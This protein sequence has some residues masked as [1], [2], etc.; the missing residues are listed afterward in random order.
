M[1]SSMYAA[2]SG[3]NADQTMLSTVSENIANVNTVGYKA[4]SVVFAQALQQTLAGAS[5]PT[6]NLGGINP[7][8]E[9]AGSAVNVGAIAVN[10]G[11]GSLQTTGINTNL[12]IQG[13]GMF[14]LYGSQGTSYSRA[15]DF[16]LDANGNLVN[17]LGEFV[18]GWNAT[19]PGTMPTLNPT[20][21]QNVT[22]PQGETIAPVETSNIALN[23]NLDSQTP[24]GTAN[25]VTV[26]VTSYDSLGNGDTVVFTFT[27][28]GPT[29]TATSSW[30][31]SYTVT[32]GSGTTSTATSVGTVTFGANGQLTSPTAPPTYTITLPPPAGSTAS[33]SVTLNLAG[34]TGYSGQSQLQGTGNGSAAGVLESFSIGASGSIVGTFSNGLTAQIGQIAMAGF[35]NPA[36][37]L[38]IGNGEWQ[39]S[40]NSGVAQIG[41]PATGSLGSLQ[42]G[43]LEGSNVNLANEFVNMIIAQQG[44]QANAKVISVA[45]QDRSTLVNMIQ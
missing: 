33:Q 31:L 35:S 10:M 8:Q 36:G 24:T 4:S 2:I 27:P 17:P 21:M 28:Q 41:A 6:A 13:N 5:A 44:Y 22:I 26:P 9:A 43:S 1:S 16:S 14:V 3:L 45:Q 30:T 40:P 39:Q 11:Q 7:E 29:G 34:L 42:A 15:G 12:A 20:T 25:A 19:T 32:N 23:G 37:L 18:Q 38:N